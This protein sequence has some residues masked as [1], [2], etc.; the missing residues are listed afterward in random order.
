MVM[1]LIAAGVAQVCS[2]VKSIKV[3]LGFSLHQIK[4]SKTLNYLTLYL[5]AY[6]EGRTIAGV[7][8]TVGWMRDLWKIGYDL[9]IVSSTI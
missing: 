2:R 5:I 6:E 1:I 8:A 7:K 4:V 9:E 3:L